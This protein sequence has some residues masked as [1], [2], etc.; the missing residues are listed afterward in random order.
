MKYFLTL[1]TIYS[2]FCFNSFAQEAER[3]KPMVGEGRMIPITTPKGEFQVWTHKKGSNETIKVLLLH[4]GPGM[5]HE[6]YEIFEN[7]F[8]EEGFEYYYY[9]Q[10]GSY[11]SDQPNEPELWQIDRFVDEVEQVRLA[12][13]LGPDNFY[14]YGQSWGGLLAIEYALKYQKNL[15]GLVISNMMS[16]V[17]DYNDYA[18]NVLM[19][20]MDPA[21]LTELKVLEAA[22]DYQ[23]PRY[24]EL[25]LEHHYVYHIL[26]KPL[27]QWPDAIMRTLSHVNQD[28]YI[29]MQGP[30][31][32]GASGIIGDWDRSDDLKNIKVP[33]LV[34]GATHDTMDPEHM[35]GMADVI[36]NGRFLLSENGS[37]LAQWDDEEVFFKGLIEF[38]KDVDKGN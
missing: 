23:N 19:A 10:L 30:S 37:H 9:D 16:S 15:K 2:I 36:P 24:L 5:T 35:R 18:E 28:V 6:Q 29:P 31:E 17:K 34:I 11:F 12:L 32:L 3:D 21:V 25:L 33:T 8:P 1:I 26:R 13:G 14:L 4:G 22:E 20:K 27:D 7:H 38:I